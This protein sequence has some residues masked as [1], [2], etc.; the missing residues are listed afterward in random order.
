MAGKYLTIDID[1]LVEPRVGKPLKKFGFPLRE[2]ASGKISLPDFR[3]RQ[4]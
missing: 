4:R 3:S 2:K 1:A